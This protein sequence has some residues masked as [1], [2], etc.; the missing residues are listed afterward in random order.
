MEKNR[1]IPLNR[2]FIPPER[3]QPVHE[4]IV[5]PAVRILK[6][7]RQWKA[8][9]S[10]I[11]SRKMLLHVADCFGYML[12]MLGMPDRGDREILWQRFSVK[13]LKRPALPDRL[14]ILFEQDVMAFSLGDIEF[15]EVKPLTSFL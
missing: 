8:F 5:K 15:R 10:P 1:F 3:S 6:R 9:A 4:E 12:V 14:S 2:V 13:G 11:G 7:N